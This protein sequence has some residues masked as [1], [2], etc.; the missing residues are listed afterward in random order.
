MIK[1]VTTLFFIL[2]FYLSTFSQQVNF[3][4]NDWQNPAVFEKGQNTPH[5]FHIPYASANDAIQN[6]PRKCRNYQLLNGQWKFKWVETP[7][8]V[9][10]EFWQPDFDV[11]EWDEIK[12]PSNWQM[13]GYGHPKF[14]NV[15]ISFENDPPNIPDYYNPTGCYK[16]KFTVLENWEDKEVM[17]R[18]EGIKSASYIWVNGQQVGY[19]QGGFE[20]VEFNITP[21]IKKGENDL[22]VQ[23]IRFSD[24][25]YLENQDMWRF[26]GIFRDVKLYAQPKTYIHDYYVVTDFDENYK[27]ATLTVEA[28]IQNQLLEAES[29]EITVDVYDVEGRSILKD[30]TIRKNFEVDSMRNV[31]VEL[32]TLVVDPPQWSAEFPNLFILLVQLKNADGKVTEAFTQ[33]IGFREVEYKDKILTVNG[34]PVKL[35]GVNSHMHHPVHG[36]AVPLETL[37]QDLLLMKQYNIN[38]VRTCHYPP[39]PEYIDLADELGMYIFDEVG[40]E[41]HNNIHLSEKPE[42]TEMYRDRSRKLVYRD[43]N[44]PAVIVWSAGNESGSGQNINEVIKTGKAIDPSRPVWMYG[45]NTFNIPFEDLVGPRYWAPVDYKNLAQGKVLPANDK[46][47]SFMDEYLA[48]TGNG[49]GGM[50]EYWEYIWKYPRLTGGAIWDWISPGI[51]TPRWILPDLSPQKNDGQIMGRPMFQQGVYGWGLEFSGHD[52]WVEFYRDPSLD[53]TGNQLTID[54]WVKP[55]E[56]P[57]PNVFVAKGAHGYGIQMT[58]A[59]T[60]EFYVFGNERISAKAKV[61]E[62]FYE[63][64]HHISGIYNGRQ[65]QLYIDNKRVA[66]TSFSGNISSTPFPLC[67]GREAETQDQGEHSGRLSKMVI[68]DVRVFNR[69]V[70]INN[71]EKEKNGL[72]LHLNFE[73]DKKDGDFYAVGL[74]GRTYGIVWPDRTVQPEINQI[75]RSGQPVKIEAIDIENGVLKVTNRH[76]FKNMNKLEGF[77]QIKVDGET[78]QRG[79]FDCDI[80]AGETGEVAINYRRPRIESTTECLLEV[81]FMLKEDLNWAPKGHEIAW[82]QFAVPTDY[83]FVDEEENNEKITATDD[84]NFI[85]INGNDFS[86]SIN[87]KTGSF[88][89][90]KYKNIEYLEG[91]PEFMVWRA[92]IANDID[93]WGSNSFGHSNFTPGMGRSIDNQLRTLGMRDLISEV[94]DYELLQVSDDEVTLKMDVFAS[95]SLDPSRRKDQWFSYSAFEQKQ[96]WT[97]SADGSIQLEQEVIPH[98]PMPDM[99]QR[100][101]LQFRLPKSFNQVQYYGRGPFENY[102]DRKTGAKIGLYHSTADS[103]YVPYIIPQEYGNRS[104][105]RWLKVHNNDDHGLLIKGNELLNFSLHKFT[106]DNLS[107]AMYAYQLEEAPNTILNVDYEV[108]GVGGT[109]IRQLQKYRVQPDVK[110]YSLT[111][112]PY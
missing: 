24:G 22:S 63:N 52:D 68:D 70:N 88:V 86:Y 101:G 65:L 110:R 71:I 81:S 100:V 28:Y 23:V 9:P 73:E 78:S 76:H 103:M 67:I 87:K 26:S 48:A 25:S 4:P 54:F 56:I 79:F 61:G 111:I 45:G 16:R 14:R 29:G 21:F 98:G 69:A 37:K 2:T 3:L 7:K 41:A 46:R 20:P 13:E 27:D 6:M 43:R 15:A 49:L 47:A 109:A 90:L 5:A 94:D 82:E 83:Y 50:D 32:A 72:V 91:G 12:V 39:T 89:S 74:G 38:C 51:K 60:L 85:R 106:T 33:K 80:P 44:H 84:E 31:K 97:F 64:W 107:R 30:G 11:S 104:D 62:D 99:L 1:R 40:D 112:K 53:I 93:P 95:S 92:P 18:F 102:P 108:S 10:V 96:T 59:E 35:N 75:K 34:V 105:V 55:S 57:Q 42:W 58:D 8:Q 77:W 36:Q 66:T 19:N 17:L